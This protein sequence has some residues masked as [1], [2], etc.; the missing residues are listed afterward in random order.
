MVEIRSE[1]GLF[2]VVDVDGGGVLVSVCSIAPLSLTTAS[3]A[4]LVSGMTAV[5]GLE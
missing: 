4:A 2:L 3:F 5:V 1:L